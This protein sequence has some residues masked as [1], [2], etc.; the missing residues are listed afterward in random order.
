MLHLDV[1]TR[2]IPFT[3]VTLKQ[4]TILTRSAGLFEET[5]VGS[6]LMNRQIK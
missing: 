5:S 3:R 4:K 6:P 1:S 2:D